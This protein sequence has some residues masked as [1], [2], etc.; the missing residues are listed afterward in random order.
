MT[1]FSNDKLISLFENKYMD[2]LNYDEWEATSIDKNQGSDFN[3]K[4]GKK[5]NPV[6]CYNCGK[7]GHIF[8]Q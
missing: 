3:D 7:L 6:M 8:M 1:T 4:G 2:I 5:P